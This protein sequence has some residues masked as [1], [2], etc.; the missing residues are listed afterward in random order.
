MGLA[1][2]DRISVQIEGNSVLTGVTGQIG[3]I[4]GMAEFKNLLIKLDKPLESGLWI[5]M[6]PEFYA[7]KIGDEL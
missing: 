6:I 3:G 7:I 5:I 1:I 4:Q 2:N